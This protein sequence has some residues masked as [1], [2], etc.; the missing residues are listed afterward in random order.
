MTVNVLVFRDWMVL[1]AGLC[2]ASAAFSHVWARNWVWAVVWFSYALA[3]F[4]LTYLQ[5]KGQ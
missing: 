1:V 4:A 3:N 2:Y 5:M